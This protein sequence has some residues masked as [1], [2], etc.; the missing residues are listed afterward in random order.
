M[1]LE[2]WA[3][4]DVGLKRSS[5]QDSFLIDRELGLFVVAD[6]MGGH[7]GGEVASLMATQKVRETVAQRMRL[8]GRDYSPKMLLQEA[9][10]HASHAIFDHGQS[11]RDLEG[12]GTT[13][14]VALLVGTSLFI[15]NVGD[16]R[17]Y[18]YSAPH[19]WQITEDHS[20]VNEQIRLGLIAEENAENFVGKNVI[21]RSVGFERD[22]ECDVIERQIEAGESL[23]ICSD[24]LTGMISKKELLDLFTESRP[25][26]I[27]P[28]AIEAA[29]KGGG[30]DNITVMVIHARPT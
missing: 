6:G 28:R 24:G 18:L 23:L 22:V 3:Q 17:A 25:S 15:S 10:T 20:L 26:E 1:T 2:V 13:L 8:L 4:S 9:C 19:M 16:S 30:E 14:V 12:M 5:N 29:K 21:T 11:Q 7:K 27:V